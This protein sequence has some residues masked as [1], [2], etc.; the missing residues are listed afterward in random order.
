MSEIKTTVSVAAIQNGTVIDHIPCGQAFRLIQLLGLQ[1]KHNKLT[2]GL[3]L[4]SRQLG[5][6]DLLKIE[7]HYLADAEASKITILAPQATINIIRQFVVEKITAALPT[8][9]SDVFICPNTAC[10]THVEP[11][12]TIFSVAQH[13]K[14]VTLTCQYCEKSFDRNQMKVKV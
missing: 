7:N 2:I 14:Q 12:E 9:I 1:D 5:L 11:V 8:N 4:P 10:I 6:K 13:G 3:N